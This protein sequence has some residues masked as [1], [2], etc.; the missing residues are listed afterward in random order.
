MNDIDGRAPRPA[1]MVV[2]RGKSLFGQ[3]NGHFRHMVTLPPP[4]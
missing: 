3:I 2:Y 4:R 1:R